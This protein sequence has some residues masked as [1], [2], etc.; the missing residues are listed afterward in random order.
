MTTKKELALYVKERI[1]KL[2]QMNTE[3]G[4]HYWVIREL[5]AMQDNFNLEEMS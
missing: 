3:F 5:K 1:Q 4:E 2:E